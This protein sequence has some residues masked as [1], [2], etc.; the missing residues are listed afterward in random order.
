MQESDEEQLGTGPAW[1]LPCPSQV[2]DPVQTSLSV[3]HEAPL[4]TGVS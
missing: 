3:S 1:Q 4:G 2:D